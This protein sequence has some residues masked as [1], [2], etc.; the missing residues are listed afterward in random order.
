MHVNYQTIH[1]NKR[2][3]LAISRGIDSG[4]DNL[5]VSIVK[6]NIVGIGEMSPG[7]SEGAHTALQGQQALQEFLTNGC[8]EFTIE[9]IYSNARAAGVAACALAALDIALWDRQAKA[10]NLP[11]YRH[12][13]LPLPSVATSVTI[14][15]NPP[16]IVEQRIPLLLDGTGVKSLKIKLG[17]T[18][19]ID[20]DKAMY[21]QVLE[22]SKDYCIQLR[23]DANGGWNTKDALHM[24]KWLA[25][26][27]C[28]YIEQPIMEG[29]EA[30]LAYLY[31]NRPLPIFIDESCRFAEDVAQWS[32]CVD[33]V[34][35]KLMKCGG[36]T[37]A[38]QIM[39]EAKKYN[40]KTMIG[41]MGESSLSISAAAALS[42]AI[43]HIDLDSQ[44]NLAPDPCHGAQLIDGVIMPND[45]PG[46]GAN[47]KPE[48]N[49]QTHKQS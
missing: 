3:P 30:D 37:G 4:S 17:S 48:F 49:Q 12:L 23:V 40:L 14:G 9:Q 34:N 16:P 44:L 33:G 5:F 35:I 38:L 39:S 21:S 45:K 47:I 18:Q 15:I 36:I 8:D 25:E 31:K 11:L 43:D 7:G 27:G 1:L 10:A 22:S 42:G 13:G 2:F 6:D 26:R 19:G 28:D 29:A 32:D 46:H 41:C 24:M 20:A